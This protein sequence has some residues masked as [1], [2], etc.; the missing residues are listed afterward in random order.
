MLL[1]ELN[2]QKQPTQEFL[3]KYAAKSQEN[4]HAEMWFQ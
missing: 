1:Q 3:K 2:E 4:T